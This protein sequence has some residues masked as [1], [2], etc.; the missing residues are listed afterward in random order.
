MEQIPNSLLLAFLKATEQDSGPTEDVLPPGPE[1][2][3]VGWECCS[4]APGAVGA[5]RSIL[6]LREAF[7]PTPLSFLGKR[8][9]Q[10]SS[11][12]FW[13]WQG[14]FSWD[15][16]CQVFVETGTAGGGQHHLP[17]NSCI[18]SSLSAFGR[19]KDNSNS[20]SSSPSSHPTRT[21]TWNSP[22]ASF[23]DQM[24]SSQTFVYKLP[25]Q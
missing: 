13:E 12:H 22:P 6:S 23:Q 20:S 4:R 14:C 9:C 2:D 7:T 19:H 21:P 25:N 17:P 3:P 10:N 18:S 11:S 1:R 16:Q 5:T 8:F 24:I 15:E